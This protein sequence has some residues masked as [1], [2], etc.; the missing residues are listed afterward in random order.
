M[1]DYKGALASE[2]AAADER[3][4]SA[5]RY[6]I[7]E[8]A[9]Y[10]YTDTKLLL[11]AGWERKGRGPWRKRGRERGRA[12]AT[13]VAAALPF[14]RNGTEHRLCIM[15]A[16]CNCTLQKAVRLAG[17]ESGRSRRHMITYAAIGSSVAHSVGVSYP[18][19]TS[20]RLF[21]WFRFG[22]LSAA[23]AA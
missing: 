16:T 9:Q 14:P 3:K 1:N 2:K 5:R 22:V 6:V 19:V 13:C 7:H 4:Q 17:I 11:V 21:S 23:M 18:V 10:G 20:S 15:S 8:R 12:W